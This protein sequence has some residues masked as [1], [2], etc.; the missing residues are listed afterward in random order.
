MPRPVAVGATPQQHL[1]LSKVYWVKGVSPEASLTDLKAKHYQVKGLA[2]RG[3]TVAQG[4]AMI[5][6]IHRG[7]ISGKLVSTKA[8]GLHLPKAK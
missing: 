1:D 5:I 6:D 8:K 2:Y 7:I 3:A 4:I